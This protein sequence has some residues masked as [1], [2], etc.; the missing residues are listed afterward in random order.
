MHFGRGSRPGVA[1]ALQK[2][3][4]IFVLVVLI[5]SLAVAYL[6]GQPGPVSAD[7]GAPPTPT[8]EPSPDPSAQPEQTASPTVEPMPDPTVEPTSEPSPLP[9]ASV[10]PSPSATPALPTGPL[11]IE[12]FTFAQVTAPRQATYLAAGAT[13]TD[14]ARFDVFRLRFDVINAFDEQYEI[15]DGTGIGVG[16]P[17]WGPRRGFFAGI[18]KSF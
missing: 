15:R 18:S 16:A 5:V 1:G 9:T 6:P 4:S 11:T 8:L 7:N 14:E 3:R 17:Q 10:E 12:L 2:Y 13:L